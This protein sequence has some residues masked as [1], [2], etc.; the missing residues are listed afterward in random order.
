VNRIVAEPAAQRVGAEPAADLVAARVS[1][2][3][4]G[5][6]AAGDRIGAARAANDVVAGSSLD[7]VG[8]AGVSPE[9]AARAALAVD[10]SGREREE[11]GG[12]SVRSVTWLSGVALASV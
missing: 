1:F 5:A 3:E 7:G 9:R 4:I 2:D 6:V 8:V 10:R 12:A 11:T